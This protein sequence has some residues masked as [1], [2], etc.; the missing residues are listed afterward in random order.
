VNQL[1]ACFSVAMKYHRTAFLERTPKLLVEVVAR[2]DAYV[3]I[4]DFLQPFCLGKEFKII[5]LNIKKEVN[6]MRVV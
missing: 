1:Q 4:E 2:G 3:Y 5:L 6:R